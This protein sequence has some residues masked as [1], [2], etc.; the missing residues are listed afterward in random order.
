L[1]RAQTKQLSYLFVEVLRDHRLQG[2]KLVLT[3]EKADG[4]VARG[5]RLLEIPMRPVAYPRLPL[6]VI[7]GPEVVLTLPKVG[8]YNR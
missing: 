2:P 1:V 6:R 5:V 7:K 8:R 3:E 4:L